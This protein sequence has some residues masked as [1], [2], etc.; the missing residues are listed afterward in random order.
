[1]AGPAYRLNQ[2]VSVYALAGFPMPR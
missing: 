2:R 1:M